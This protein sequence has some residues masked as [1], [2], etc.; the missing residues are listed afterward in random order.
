MASPLRTGLVAC[1]EVCEHKHLPALR[2]V[3]GI[4]VVAV[5]DPDAAR[6]SHVAS[7]YGI[8]G[9]FRDAASML[10][11]ER[12]DCVGVLTPPGEHADIAIQALAASCHV[13]VEKPVTLTLA[14][15]DALLAAAAKAP[16]VAYMGC[17]ICD[18]TAWC[19]RQG[20]RFARV[21]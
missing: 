1:G 12:L 18:G 17:S 16:T 4:D 10:V 20:T 3:P 13:L 15:A 7:R 2:R 8:G 21:S 5:A 6:A 11:A 9:V 19:G 14:G